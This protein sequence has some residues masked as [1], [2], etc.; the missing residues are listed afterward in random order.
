MVNDPFLS[1]YYQ[2]LGQ[3]PFH[4]NYMMQGISDTLYFCTSITARTQYLLLNFNICI[5][6]L[7]NYEFSIIYYLCS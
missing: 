2:C 7:T 4:R 5:F 1:L 3:D 6:I